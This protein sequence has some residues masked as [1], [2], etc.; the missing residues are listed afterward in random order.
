MG[1]LFCP[2]CIRGLEVAH[3]LLGFEKNIFHFLATRI[4]VVLSSRVSDAPA[5]DALA[6]LEAG[7]NIDFFS[8][9]RS[10]SVVQ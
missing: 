4:T 10:L 9:R 6:D 5:W 2:L 8:A 7:Y 1:C 3:W